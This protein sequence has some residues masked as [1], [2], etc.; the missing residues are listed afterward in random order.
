M[1]LCCWQNWRGG[2]KKCGGSFSYLQKRTH[3]FSASCAD[4]MK[5][6]NELQPHADPLSADHAETVTKAGIL[7]DGCSHWLCPDVLRGLW[8][9]RLSGCLPGQSS[10]PCVP[11]ACAKCSITSSD[12]SFC[13]WCW[14]EVVFTRLT[15]EFIWLWED[16]LSSSIVKMKIKK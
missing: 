13:S 6:F 1:A 10:R 12:S 14:R 15:N 7:R 5:A 4:K 8:W 3:C 2:K 11:W 9:P 16:G